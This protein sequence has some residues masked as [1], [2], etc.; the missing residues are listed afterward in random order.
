MNLDQMSDQI[1][2]G[3]GSVAIVVD[4]NAGLYGGLVERLEQKSYPMGSH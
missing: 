3:G 1:A 2:P 4:C